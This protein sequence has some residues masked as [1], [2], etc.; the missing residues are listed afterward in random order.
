[1][2]RKRLRP[3]FRNKPTILL[4]VLF[5]FIAISLITWA[6]PLNAISCMFTDTRIQDY[7]IEAVNDL[8]LVI[9]WDGK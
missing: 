3:C 8:I 6:L 7:F 1:M 2:N 9:K 4:K 5:G